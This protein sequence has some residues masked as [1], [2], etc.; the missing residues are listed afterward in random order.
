MNE[1]A[2]SPKCFHCRQRAV[3][4]TPVP[5]RTTI[6]HD[7]REY[8]VYIPDLV[9][10]KCGHCQEIAFDDEANRQIDLAFRREANLFTPEEIRSNAW[11]L[12]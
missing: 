8:S 6:S 1:R 3:A 9:V 11:P 12:I 4:L 5:Y 7:G 2:F 10:P